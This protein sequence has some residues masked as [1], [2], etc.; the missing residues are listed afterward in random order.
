MSFMKRT[1]ALRVSHLIQKK[2]KMK[3]K[4]ESRIVPDRLVEPSPETQIR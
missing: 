2:K 4:L 3:K 1:A